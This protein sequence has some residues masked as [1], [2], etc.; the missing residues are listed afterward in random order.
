MSS[1]PP[2]FLTLPGEIRNLIYAHLLVLPPPSTSPALTG[3][4]PLHPQ[5]L[6]VSQQIYAE[7]LPFL[8]AYNTFIAHPARLCRLPQ[9]RRWLD[10]VTALALRAR[11]RR[12]HIFV[13]LECDASFSAEEAARAFSGM[14]ELTIEVFQ[15][16]F[17]GSG[18]HV[19]R[20]FEGVREVQR[21]RVLGCVQCVALWPGYVEELTRKMMSKKEGGLEVDKE[22]AAMGGLEGVCRRLEVL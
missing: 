12:Y 9:L 11:I 7:A 1:P 14:E 19:L 13:R 21:A 20:L 17:R 16:R 3:K 22:E 10:P 4:A 6:R 15:S 2:S 18:S 5:I 8:Y